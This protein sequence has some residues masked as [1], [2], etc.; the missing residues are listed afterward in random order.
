LNVL[1]KEQEEPVRK[2]IMWLIAS[3]YKYIIKS[4]QEWP[5]LLKFLNDLLTSTV[6][7]QILVVQI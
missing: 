4:K 6:P 5:E 7:E 3:S 2:Q 1:V